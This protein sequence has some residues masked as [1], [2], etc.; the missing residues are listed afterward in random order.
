MPNCVSFPSHNS[1]K[2]GKFGRLG[3]W[4]QVAIKSFCGE[5][6]LCLCL[7]SPTHAVTENAGMAFGPSHFQAM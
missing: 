2:A 5:E 7:V 4:L 3:R 1:L 6:A